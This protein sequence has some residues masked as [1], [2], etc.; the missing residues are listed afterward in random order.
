MSGFE[1]VGMS[2]ENCTWSAVKKG[3][4]D[5]YGDWKRVGDSMALTTIEG[6][7]G[8][9]RRRRGGPRRKWMDNIITWEGRV[10]QAH[11]KARE[12]RSTVH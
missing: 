2:E 12:R 9:L 6:E 4:I 11:W 8:C 10:E 7:I 5:K 3:N 1:K